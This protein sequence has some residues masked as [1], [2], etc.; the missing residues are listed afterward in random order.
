MSSKYFQHIADIFQDFGS[1]KCLWQLRLTPTAYHATAAEIER[2][3]EEKTNLKLIAVLM[4][5]EH[6]FPG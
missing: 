1:T 4:V 3:R 2:Q 6:S 5:I